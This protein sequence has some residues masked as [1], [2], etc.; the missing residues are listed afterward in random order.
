MNME[1][2]ILTPG[3]YHSTRLCTVCVTLFSTSEIESI[4]NAP[5]WNSQWVSIDYHETFG[6]LEAVVS[7]CCQ[8]CTLVLV[9]FS[10]E[11]R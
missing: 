7:E 1:T 10:N 8:F 3:N 5:T 2:K 11:D 9:S 4:K 6:A